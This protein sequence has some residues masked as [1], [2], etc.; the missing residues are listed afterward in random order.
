MIKYQYGG[1]RMVKIAVTNQKGG[2]GKTTIT[3]HLL[4][5]FANDGKKVIAVDTDPQGNL[6]SC[7]LDE[8]PSESNIKRIFEDTIPK[9]INVAQNIDLIGSNISLSKYEADAKFANFFRLRELLESSSIKDTYDVAIIDTP[10]SLGLFT[11][12]ALISSNY[13]IIP[14]DTSKFALLGLEDLMDSVE[15]VRKSTGSTIKVLGILFSMTQERLVYYKRLR[16]EL[17][18]KY[19]DYL[20]TVNIPQTVLLKEAI[21]SKRP[22]F[23]IYPEHKAS[24]AFKE[25]YE[26][27]KSRMKNA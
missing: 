9:S 4:H 15:K 27:I 26:E 13:V 23:E 2:V 16:E 14:L 17:E 24:V 22:I 19:K 5:L 12:N 11:S 21:S 20:F 8:I 6:T 3:F 10:P 1:E 25:L 7:F 18:K